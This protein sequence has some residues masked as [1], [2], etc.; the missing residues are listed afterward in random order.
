MLCAMGLHVPETHLGSKACI[1]FCSQV[2]PYTSLNG[3]RR[4]ASDRIQFKQLIQLASKDYPRKRSVQFVEMLAYLGSE[5][6][7]RLK[8]LA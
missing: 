8:S 2:F 5:F 4:K 1:L 6:G 7:V 3:L